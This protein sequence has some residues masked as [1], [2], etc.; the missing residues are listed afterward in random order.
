[1]II[2]EL[3]KEKE[4]P[5]IEL[6]HGS[7]GSEHPGYNYSKGERIKQFPDYYF[8]FPEFWKN[9]ARFPIEQDYL[10]CSWKAF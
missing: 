7:E 8:A 2:T 1:M 9:Q 5:V 10:V 4:I 3:A 6:Q